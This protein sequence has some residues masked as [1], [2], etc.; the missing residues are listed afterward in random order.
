M[1]TATL[2]RLSM[3][4]GV[5][6]VNRESGNRRREEGQGYRGPEG[7]IDRSGFV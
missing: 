4:S 6:G 7:I 1:E 5:E 3:D 2:R